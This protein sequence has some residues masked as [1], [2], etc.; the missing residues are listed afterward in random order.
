MHTNVAATLSSTIA[1]VV[2]GMLAMPASAATIFSASMTGAELAASENVSFPAGPPQLWGDSAEFF[3]EA[4]NQLL[5]QWDLLP[6]GPRGPLQFTVNV[7]YNPIES[8][9][10]ND[11]VFAIAD[12]THFAGIFRTDNDDSSASTLEGTVSAKSVALGPGESIVTGLGSVQPFSFELYT[13]PTTISDYAEGSFSSTQVFQVP[14]AVIDPSRPLSLILASGDVS[15]GE[16]YM[17]NS[18]SVS[19]D[20]IPEPSTAT[21]LLSALGVWIAVRAAGRRRQS[22]V[23]A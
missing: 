9:G 20:A 7:D 5:M 6:S 3:N 19:I 15:L 21:L 16:K 1:L 4:E 8:D 13:I 17:L 11:P 2:T 10:D 18:V 22:A 14:G 23:P 12:G